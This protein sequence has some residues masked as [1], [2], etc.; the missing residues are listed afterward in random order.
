MI[1]GIGR[2]RAMEGSVVGRENGWSLEKGTVLKRN[3]WTE[4]AR[5]EG[6]EERR[7]MSATLV[8][9]GEETPSV[10][11]GTSNTLMVGEK[12]VRSQLMTMTRQVTL[13]QDM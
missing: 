5:V 12:H 8:G 10:K 1:E 7:L 11:D 9:G 13:V 4:R 2:Y 6:L 3:N